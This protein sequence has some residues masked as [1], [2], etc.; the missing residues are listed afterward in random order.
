[1]KRLKT[2]NDEGSPILDHI[3][4]ELFKEKEILH[5]NYSLHTSYL[6]VP[7]L[8]KVDKLLFML[9]NNL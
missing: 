4:E 1:M 6:E 3:E 8:Q 5:P 9:K 7:L 2:E